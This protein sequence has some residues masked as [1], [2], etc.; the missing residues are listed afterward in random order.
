MAGRMGL[1]CDREAGRMR[2]FA[3]ANPKFNAKADWDATFR[4]WLDNAFDRLPSWEKEKLQAKAQLQ[5]ARVSD[6]ERK[7]AFEA[8]RAQKDRENEAL[9]ALPAPKPRQ[10]G[11]STSL[12]DLLKGML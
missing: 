8:F 7:R 4:N 5:S 1:D 12:G 3:A 2:D 10:S 9:D 11:E 6:E